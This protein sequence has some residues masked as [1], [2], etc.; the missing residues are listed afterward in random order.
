MKPVYVTAEPVGSAGLSWNDKYRNLYGAQNGQVDLLEIRSSP[1]TPS[2]SRISA[3][4]TAA[5]DAAAP[6]PTLPAAKSWRSSPLLVEAA[7]SLRRQQPPPGG[8]GG[9]GGGKGGGGGG[10]GG[11]G[12]EKKEEKPPDLKV[13]S[14]GC[15][16]YR[17]SRAILRSSRA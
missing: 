8:G 17:C 1:S 5:F 7:D 15:A 12:G 14:G 6:Y 2:S 11:G 10:K 13:N 16:R 3:L 9:G 4:A